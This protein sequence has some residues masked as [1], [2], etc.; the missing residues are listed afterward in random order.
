MEL[1][2][3]VPGCWRPLGLGDATGT[4]FE[5]RVRSTT[6]QLVLWADMPA[7]YTSGFCSDAL[8]GNLSLQLA[9]LSGP[10]AI[11]PAIGAWSVVM[12]LQ[13]LLQDLASL[14]RQVHG[15]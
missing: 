14:I 8:A 7:I 3:C 12:G 9:R 1:R 11:S 6:S 5:T 15:E 4:R 10:A 13:G 2:T